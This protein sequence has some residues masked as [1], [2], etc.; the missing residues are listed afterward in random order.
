M[1]GG[2]S[3]W[4]GRAGEVVY[5]LIKAILPGASANSVEKNPH[6]LLFYVGLLFCHFQKSILKLTLTTSSVDFRSDG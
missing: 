1:Q 3:F 6:F 4:S 2:R 5:H